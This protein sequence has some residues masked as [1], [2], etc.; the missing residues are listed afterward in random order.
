MKRSTAKVDWQHRGVPD[1]ALVRALGRWAGTA[2]GLIVLAPLL[3]LVAA[4][5][6]DR[7]PRGNV[8]ITLFPAA[9]TVLDPFLGNAVRN[10]VAVALAAALGSLA[11]GV[12]IGLAFGRWRFWGR[13]ILWG[14]ILAPLAVPPAIAAL[15]LRSTFGPS[16]SWRAGW[17][18]FSARTGLEP[19]WGAWCWVA[20]AS[21]IPLVVLATARALAQIE[22]GWEDA[23]RLVGASRLRI[24]WEIVWP[25][26]RPTAVRASGVVFTTTMAEPGAPIVLGLRRTLGFQLVESVL[27]PD[28]APHGAALALAVIVYAAIA[29]VVFRWW[30]RSLLTSTGQRPLGRPRRA[31]AIQAAAHMTLLG[32]VAIVAWLPVAPLL[33]LSLATAPG[34]SSGRLSGAAH[35]ILGLLHDPVIRRVGLNS[36]ALGAGVLCLDL[37]LART[38]VAWENRHRTWLRRLVSVPEV[39][40]PLVFGVAAL[41]VPHVA[42][43]A[44]TA[45][46]AM[47]GAGALVRGLRGVNAVLDPYQTPALLLLAVTAAR[48]AYLARS[49]Q[50]GMRRYRPSLASAALNLGAVPAR[51]RRLARVG[52]FGASL[53]A[54]AFSITQAATNLAPALVVTPTMESRTVLPALL[55][56]ADEPGGGLER[57]ATLGLCAVVVN[58]AAFILAACDRDG[59]R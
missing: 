18:L 19:G 7:G 42:A 48:G 22:P 51:A 53:G 14:L 32:I 50:G 49:V 36:L 21:G 35:A 55:I 24:W 38:A 47:G 31:A 58:A 41:A 57:A 37:L 54:I 30:G 25:A 10:S 27:G 1:I 12:P 40:P 52:W 59:L 44:S 45:L 9:L 28:P 56:L 23:A 26:I 43:I 15:G 5:V 34:D 20:L 16:G 13:R 11:I 17:N 4:A 39:I 8:R 2:L 6:L 33:V 46:E 29:T 3:A